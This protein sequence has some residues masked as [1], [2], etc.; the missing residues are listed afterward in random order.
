MLLKEKNF[1]FNYMITYTV[2]THV[3]YEY[4]NQVTLQIVL[5]ERLLEIL[6]DPLI[7]TCSL[8]GY[9]GGMCSIGPFLCV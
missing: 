3:S 9:I 5:A 4:L 8:L 1:N 2:V 6:Q 7:A